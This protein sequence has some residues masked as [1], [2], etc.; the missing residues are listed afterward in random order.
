MTG[1]LDAYEAQD[2]KIIEPVGDILKASLSNQVA[3]VWR[4]FSVDR[5]YLD[6]PM[7][8]IQ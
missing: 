3:K 6:R 8:Q 1:S 2:R 7:D 4:S 5:F